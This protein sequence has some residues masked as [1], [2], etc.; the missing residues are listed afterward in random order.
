MEFGITLIY[1]TK[2]LGL[3]NSVPS[4]SNTDYALST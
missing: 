4:I 3:L 1:M 2:I